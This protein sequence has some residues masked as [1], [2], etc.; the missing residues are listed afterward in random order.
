MHVKSMRNGS[1]NNFA[2]EP[3][4]SDVPQNEPWIALVKRGACDFDVKLHNAFL[5][6]AAAMVVYDREESV[7]LQDMRLTAC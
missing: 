1:I 2:C 4:I 5:K 6:N 7:T 3:I